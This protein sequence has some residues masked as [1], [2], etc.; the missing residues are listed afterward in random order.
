MY[1]NGILG[2]WVGFLAK[3]KLKDRI[4]DFKAINGRLTNARI[5]AKS[6]NMSLVN[7]YKPTEETEDQIKDKFYEELEKIM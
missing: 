2:H 6:F 1:V 3:K 7:V 4:M 5:H